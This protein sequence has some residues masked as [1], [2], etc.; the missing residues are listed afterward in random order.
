MAELKQYTKEE[1]AGMLDVQ[2][3]EHAMELIQ[4]WVDRGDGC[5][6][7]ENHDL[8]SAGAGHKQFVSYGSNAA[9]LPTRRV[10]E[11]NGRWAEP[12]QKLPDIAGSINWRYQLIGVYNPNLTKKE[13]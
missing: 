6:V 11:A 5:A 10:G 2:N 1:I 9:Q 4:R 8:S 13:N 7:Y 3:S 12:P